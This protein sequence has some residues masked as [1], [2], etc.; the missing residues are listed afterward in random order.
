M[1]ARHACEESELKCKDYRLDTKYIQSLAV[2]L[3][4]LAEEPDD[5]DLGKKLHKVCENVS[6]R[7]K[8]CDDGG[9]EKQR[10]RGKG[11][12]K[13]PFLLPCSFVVSI[14]RFSSAPSHTHS[15]QHIST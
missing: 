13:L 12:D 5:C 9:I 3:I 6:M 10:K 2:F 1:P 7:I 8:A 14:P 4:F 11:N 15:S